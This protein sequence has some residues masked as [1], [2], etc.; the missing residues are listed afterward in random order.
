MEHAMDDMTPRLDPLLERVVREL[1]APIDLFPGFDR[2]VL[3]RL[4]R[5]RAPRMLRFRHR[6]TWAA[7]L[8]AV[9]AVLLLVLMNNL[10]GPE[11]MV[12]FAIQDPSAR[13]VSIVGDFNDWD[14]AMTPMAR[15]RDGEWK[16]D[17]ELAPG[18]YRYSY[19]VDGSTWVADPVRPAIPDRDFDAPTSLVTVQEL[20]P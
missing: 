7:S 6:L 15:G 11:S 10:T 4:A 8:A 20:S 14:P 2:R 18:R 9:A 1:K 5:E 16:A 3:D 17:L 19:L 12:R 13:S